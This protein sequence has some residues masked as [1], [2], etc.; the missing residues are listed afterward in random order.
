MF[1]CLKV[2]RR[3]YWRNVCSEVNILWFWSIWR[4]PVGF[5]ETMLG[6]FH[7]FLTWR[8]NWWWN[9]SSVAALHEFTQTQKKCVDVF[10]SLLIYLFVFWRISSSHR[11]LGF[12]CSYNV[13]YDKTNTTDIVWSLLT[14]PSAWC[15]VFSVCFRH[16]YALGQRVWK[17]WKKRYFVL[18]QVRNGESGWSASI[19]GWFWRKSLKL[20]PF[21]LTGRLC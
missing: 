7:C 4:R 10:S 11:H 18:V 1:Q 21:Y 12:K 9:Y 19:C 20:F 15:R 13:L 5:W 14:F 6:V 8:I 17:R 3:E 2:M 16:L